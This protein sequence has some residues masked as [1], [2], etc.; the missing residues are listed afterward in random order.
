VALGVVAGAAVGSMMWGPLLWWWGRRKK[1]HRLHC[2]LNMY[3]V[4]GIPP[5][6]LLKLNYKLFWFVYCLFVCQ[7]N[8]HPYKRSKL[9]ICEELKGYILLLNEDQNY[10]WN[11]N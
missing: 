3:T 4:Q 9:P 7:F 2:N 11:W 8:F 1:V 5:P 10:T 6:L